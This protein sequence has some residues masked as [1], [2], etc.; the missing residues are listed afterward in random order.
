MKRI[1]YGVV[2]IAVLVVA[3]YVPIKSNFYVALWDAY[4]GGSIEKNGIVLPLIG[5]MYVQPS[6]KGNDVIVLGVRD[7]SGELFPG[8]SMMSLQ[9]EERKSFMR[10]LRGA[11][12]RCSDRSDCKIL[13]ANKCD[14][15]S[16]MVF[17][18]IVYN[19]YSPELDARYHGFFYHADT[20][21]LIQFH[22]DTVSSYNVYLD[23][24]N[25]AL[26]K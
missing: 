21:L 7:G 16:G 15:D 19:E 26:V 20:G 25:H 13:Y 12:A 10:A 17:D 6:V 8:H 22:A 18:C 14:V 24:I 23:S 3:L 9:D 2:F 5:P 1:I 4:Y 11:Y